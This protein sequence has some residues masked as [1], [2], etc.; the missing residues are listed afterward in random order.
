MIVQYI[1]LMVI[2]GIA[3]WYTIKKIRAPFHKDEEC[4][5]GCA[6]CSALDKLEDIKE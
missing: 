4:G 6:K 2:I 5:G 3:T 1:L